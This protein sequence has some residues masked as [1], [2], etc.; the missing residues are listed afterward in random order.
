MTLVDHLF[1][2]DSPREPEKACRK[3]GVTKPLAA[4]HEQPGMRDG[5]RHDCKDCH[6]AAHKEWY[7]RN[8]EDEIRRV[9][10]W[11][12][13]NSDRF[14]ESQRRRRL[15]RG[16]AYKR[17]ERDGHL[18]R[19][20][21]L[22]LSDFD[23]LVRTQ[24]GMCAICERQLRDKLHVDHDH[25]TGAVRGLLCGKCNMA[26]GLLGDDPS[27]LRSAEIYLRRSRR[28]AG[29]QRPSR[30]SQRRLLAPEASHKDD[31]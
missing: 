12:Q 25:R 5:H 4:F 17:Q 3:C 22:R 11:Q 2:L 23:E 7:L 28:V 24:L 9:K 16:D 31:Q 27:L 14:N 20:Y 21:G 15:Q 19:K 13:A 8:R 6:N 18:R 1:S 29:Q 10:L 26:I 30:H